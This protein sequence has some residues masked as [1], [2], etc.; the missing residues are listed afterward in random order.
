MRLMASRKDPQERNREANVLLELYMRDAAS[1]E[2][3]DAN[4]EC[5]LKALLNGASD[6]A[7]G[8]A[9]ALNVPTSA[10][11]LRFDVLGESDAAIHKRVARVLRVIERETDLEL[12]RSSVET[13][14]LLAA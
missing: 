2:V 7:L 9:V 13:G 12:T 11:K 3:L 8:P 14:E 5:V 10:I 6:I 1:E 4:S